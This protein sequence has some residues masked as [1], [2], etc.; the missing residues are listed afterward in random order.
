MEFDNEFES[1]LKKIKINY[2]IVRGFKG[3][4]RGFL[5]SIIAVIIYLLIGIF[6]GIT[7]KFNYLLMI[8]SLPVIM[9]LFIGL[10]WTVPVDRVIKVIDKKNGLKERLITLYE[11]RDSEDHN[12]FIKPLQREVVGELSQ[13]N[14]RFFHFNWMPE[15]K[16]MGVLA[17]VIVFMVVWINTSDLSYY[18]FLNQPKEKEE[19]AQKQEELDLKEKDKEQLQLLDPMDIPQK[20]TLD[21]EGNTGSQDNPGEKYSDELKERISR[22]EDQRESDEEN[23]KDRMKKEEGGQD[24]NEK[25]NPSGAKGN[26]SK[27]DG[28]QAA[29]SG[30]NEEDNQQSSEEGATSAVKKGESDNDENMLLKRKDDSRD[31][32]PP[33][34][35]KDKGETIPSEQKD[36]KQKEGDKSNNTS[37]NK[38][39]IITDKKE[40]QLKDERNM[41]I[42]SGKGDK[43]EQSENES[44]RGAGST[45][46]DSK[47][48]SESLNPNEN[49]KG[50]KLKSQ[51]I[52]ESYLNSF[53]EEL[54]P[55]DVEG[56]ED[57]AVNN[58]LQHRKYLLDSLDHQNIP[59]VHKKIIKDYFSIIRD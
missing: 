35:E 8:F 15:L 7:L 26:K 39:N 53:L 47:G 58:Y 37:K 43:T 25:A 45:P 41:S 28:G 1:L 36:N 16:Y 5:V 13:I 32:S 44:T 10:F 55:P 2:R 4:L 50:S 49:L 51:L 17:S 24:F 56:K 31:Q 20:E 14:C 6:L 9:G 34:D 48:Q 12:P 59:A 52:K 42:G 22:K 54:Y 46:G 19:I 11:Y 33:G 29:A 40:V 27:E 21:E 30:G 38:Q 23:L 57:L 3:F 18:S